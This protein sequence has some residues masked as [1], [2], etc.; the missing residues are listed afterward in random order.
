MLFDVILTPLTCPDCGFGTVGDPAEVPT[1]IWH[2]PDQRRIVVGDRYPFLGLAHDDE[3][4][5]V[6]PTGNPEAVAVLELWDCACT[7]GPGWVRVRVGGDGT[8]LSV[9]A[10]AKTRRELL[11]FDY[12]TQDIWPFF[13]VTT[14]LPFYVESYGLTRPRHDW[15]ELLAVELGPGG[16][17][18][19]P[20]D[21]RHDEESRAGDSNDD[22]DD[23]LGDAAMTSS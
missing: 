16:D 10:V 5:R 21:D 15:V 3:Y 13:E 23:D 1:R 19:S 6:R 17:D 20:G 9:E 12:A 4:V 8:L 14:G 22:G 11:R 2:D 7:N 18:E